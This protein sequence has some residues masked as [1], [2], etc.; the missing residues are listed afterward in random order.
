MIENVIESAQNRI[1]ARRK[2][3]EYEFM[4][5]KNRDVDSALKEGWEIQ[6]SHKTTATL[7]RKK[8][9]DVWLEDRV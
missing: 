6:K 4:K 2:K 5:M 8:R 1:M 9:K 3:S 7:K